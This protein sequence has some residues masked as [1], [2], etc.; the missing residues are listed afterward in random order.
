[1]K[2]IRRLTLALVTL[3]GLLSQ[4]A[5]ANA[6]LE[7]TYLLNVT[8]RYH[9]SEIAM[10]LGDGG[11]ELANG[12]FVDFRRWYEPKWID[13]EFHMLTQLSDDFGI[14]WGFSTG[15]WGEKYKIDPAFKVG[16]I[17]QRRFSPWSSMSF[18]ATYLFRGRFNEKSCVADYGDI[19]GVQAVNCR[20][21]ASVAEPSETL[22]YLVKAKP[23]DKLW[24]GAKYQLTF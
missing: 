22:E 13:V 5:S 3:S 17:A 9:L 14:L 23:R 21:A 20:L 24:F 19:G 18:S 11:Y 15:E 16:A 4:G 6:F 10:K 12:A 2:L 1:M 7:N 8:H